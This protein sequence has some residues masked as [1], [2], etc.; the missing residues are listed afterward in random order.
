VAGEAGYVGLILPVLS[1]IQTRL[2]NLYWRQNLKQGRV[3]LIVG[4]VDTTD[5]VD[6]FILASPWT[7]FY[8]FALATGSASIPV[9]DDGALGMNVN[10][11]L[12]D[13]L[14][15]LAGF[16]DSNADSTDPFNGF[17]TF[18]DHEFFK[19]LEL[20]WTT[21][22]DRFYL[23]NTHVTYWHA[24]EREVAGVS[25]GWGV[26]FSFT[27]S[28]DE[29]W[30]PFLRGGYASDGGSLLQKTVST[31]F[32]RHLKD[33]RSLIGMG[34]NFG[35]PNED[36]FGSGLR[37]QTT[38]EL[39]ARLVLAR[40]FEVTPDLQLILDP[41]KNPAVNQTW[42]WGLRARLAF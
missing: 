10:A 35:E 14:Y 4:M 12:T 7:T 31:G 29:K 2:T 25:G 32:G 13:K 41:A 6:L 19:T 16:A 11:M 39:F 21:S 28:F 15:L 17:S 9:P 34:V 33:G 37:D 18:G 38:I 20:G 1:D 24:D 3:E 23:D 8:N 5:W 30:M 27:H 36:T 42:V 22:Q 26:N 40:N